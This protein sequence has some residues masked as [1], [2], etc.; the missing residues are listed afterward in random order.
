MSPAWDCR[1]VVTLRVSYKVGWAFFLTFYGN[2][3]SKYARSLA[4]NTQYCVHW[5]TLETESLVRWQQ[6][7]AKCS[8]FTPGGMRWD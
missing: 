1:V 6:S 7:A 3:K 4:V 2:E 5:Q 8:G